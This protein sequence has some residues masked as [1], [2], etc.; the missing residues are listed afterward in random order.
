M[1][2]LATP[3]QYEPALDGLNAIR[4]MQLANVVKTDIVCP[5]MC[6]NPATVDKPAVGMLA[7]CSQQGALLKSKPFWADTIY[8]YNVAIVVGDEVHITFP[9]YVLGVIAKYTLTGP[10][11]V[12]WCN[13]AYTINYRGLATEYWTRLPFVGK[14]IHFIVDGMPD[15]TGALLIKGFYKG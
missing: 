5:V 10:M 9:M 14:D 6:K 8:E 1:P 15:V 3:I 12:D 4:P 2:K 13:D 7:R 11:G